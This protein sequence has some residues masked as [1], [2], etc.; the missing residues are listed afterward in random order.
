L[1]LS[2]VSTPKLIDQVRRDAPDALLVGFK[3]L[4][5]AAPA[6]LISEARA[7]GR[8][9]KAN[10][11]VAN[12]VKKGKYRAFIVAPQGVVPEACSK[13]ELVDLLVMYAEAFFRASPGCTCSCGCK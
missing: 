11:I 9:S 2:L 10:L 1:S 8:R 6:P 7:L 3:F 4:P 12:T 13:A 5:E